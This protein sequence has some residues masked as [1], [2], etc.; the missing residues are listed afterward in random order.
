MN[1]FNVKSTVFLGL[2]SIMVGFNRPAKAAE[3]CV[4]ISLVGGS[5]NQITKAVSQPT[6]PGPFGIDIT[7][8]NWNTDWAIPG[9]QRFKR[10]VTTV[11]S[12]K[13]GTF[14]IKMYLKYSDQTTG[15]FYNTEGVQLNPGQPLIIDATP[16][17]EDQP[18]QVNLFMGGLNH[19]GNSYTASVVGCY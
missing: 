5:G 10:F 17:P 3:T 8:N 14:D 18:Y 4:P 1:N 11:S 19:I 2:L 15:E 9:G 7:R 6:I 12:D 16:R 13:G